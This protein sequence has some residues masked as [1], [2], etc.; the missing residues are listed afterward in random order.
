MA[1]GLVCFS[2]IWLRYKRPDLPRHFKVWGYP[3]VPA[4]GVL[5]VL[6]LAWIGVEHAIR[7]WFFWFVLGDRGAVLRMALLDEPDAQPGGR[8]A[9]AAR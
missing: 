5:I 8:S 1:F 2:V 3:V 7:V 6:L 9:G 4:I